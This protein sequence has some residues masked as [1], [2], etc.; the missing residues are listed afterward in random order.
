MKERH[1]SRELLDLFALGDLP[2]AEAE[3]AE[4][5][6][7]A[8]ADCRERAGESSALLSLP[9][10][11]WLGSDYDRAFDRAVLGAVEQ[12][13][14]LR[15]EARGAEDLLAELLREP[16]PE[17]R[18]KIQEE[19]RFHSLKLCQLLRTRSYDHRFSDPG[20]VRE[21]AELAAGLAQFLDPRRYGSS[22]VE[23][24]RA[25]SWCSLSN[26]FRIVSDFWRAERALRQAWSHYERSYGDAST[27]AEL[28]NFTASL[29]ISQGRLSEA[30]GLLDRAIDIY[31]DGQQSQLEGAMMIQKGTALFDDGRYA[32][33]ISAVRSGL[34]RTGM[35]S[36]R[37]LLI[38]RHNLSAT[39]IDNEAIGEARELIEETRPLY[40]EMGEPAILA[41]W[42]WIEAEL[43]EALGREVEA[44]TAFRE[45]RQLLLDQQMGQ[46]VFLISL[47]LA[48]FY[49]QAG[50][51]REVREVLAEMIPLGEI[52]ANPRQVLAARLLYERAV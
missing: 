37:L 47:S 25:L 22:L 18:R 28:L 41:R 52:V 40:R 24:A 45:A 33:A 39:L 15:R 2:A 43:A 27:N 9:L 34:A 44:E 21:S 8:C 23:D 20:I 17:R 4:R 30:V 29:R 12:F 42:R 51:R 5:H 32:E 19:E 49:A 38:G 13:A 7:E 50:R 31:R 46:D 3:E 11:D 10:L 35:E 26:A 1:L 14:G 36:P 48:R 6:L 16:A